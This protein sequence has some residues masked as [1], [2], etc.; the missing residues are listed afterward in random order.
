MAIINEV[1]ITGRSYRILVDKAAKLWQ[2]VSY[3]THSS[4]VEFKDGKTAEEKVGAINGITSDISKEDEDIAA[5]IKPVHIMKTNL[6]NGII[7]D[8]IQLVIQED[9]SLGWKKDGAD[10]VTPF[11]RAWELTLKVEVF[12]IPGFQPEFKATYL[13]TY[14]YNPITKS[15]Q[16]Y[17]TKITEDTSPSKTASVSKYKSGVKTN[18]HNSAHA[19]QQTWYD[20]HSSVWVT[21]HSF[22]FI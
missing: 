2:K 22:K 20:A 9:G 1:S 19:S 3:W 13:V 5:S 14:R 4:D 18:V 11:S 17:N 7:N 16:Y 15:V 12:C 10:T 8:R 6:D 21:L